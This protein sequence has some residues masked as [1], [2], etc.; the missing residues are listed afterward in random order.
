MNLENRDLKYKHLLID[1]CEVDN[2]DNTLSPK[3]R[4]K[5]VAFIKKWLNQDIKPIECEHNNRNTDRRTYSTCLDCDEHS[6][7]PDL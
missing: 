4:K 7:H 3:Q 5:R 1:D 6:E 2:I